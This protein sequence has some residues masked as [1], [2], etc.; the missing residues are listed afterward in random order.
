[1]V[2]QCDLRIVLLLDLHD[3]VKE[4]VTTPVSALQVKAGCWEHKRLFTIVV[5]KTICRAAKSKISGIHLWIVVVITEPRIN[6]SFSCCTV[7]G[8]WIKLTDR[9]AYF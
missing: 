5:G 8:I 7:V 3:T 2:A 4:A 6:C 9:E 1:M